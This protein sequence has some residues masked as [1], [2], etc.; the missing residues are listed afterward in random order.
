[1][2]EAQENKT[3]TE[4]LSYS[5]RQSIKVDLSHSWSWKRVTEGWQ[6]IYNVISAYKYL[7][8]MV[9]VIFWRYNNL[10]CSMVSLIYVP[11]T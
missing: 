4:V 3:E 7:I 1:M 11:D 8:T 6:S 5:C 2:Q 9:V 10:A